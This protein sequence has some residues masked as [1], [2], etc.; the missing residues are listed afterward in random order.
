[1]EVSA[2][3][4]WKKLGELEDRAIDWKAHPAFEDVDPYVA[5]ADATHFAGTGVG[6]KPKRL[7]FLIRLAV[8]KCDPAMLA[9]ATLPFTMTGASRLYVGTGPVFVT[10]SIG[11]EHVLALRTGKCINIGTDEA[12]DWRQIEIAAVLAAPRVSNVD[13]TTAGIAAAKEISWASRPLIAFVDD[14]CPFANAAYLR[15]MGG[16]PSTRV[17]HLWDQ[18]SEIAPQGYWRPVPGFG[19]GRQISAVELDKVLKRN[20]LSATEVDEDACYRELGLD[21]LAGARFS[22]GA[23]MM[24]LAAGAPDPS[25]SRDC[26]ALALDAA[27]QADII[28]VQLP[29]DVM[30]DTS[31]GGLPRHVLD[32]LRYIDLMAIEIANGKV[33]KRPVVV[34]LSVGAAAGPHDGT[35]LVEQAIDDFIGQ[36]P[37]CAVVAAAGNGRSRA[38]HAKTSLPQQGQSRFVWCVA[39]DDGTDSF[40]ELWVAR[41]SDSGRSGS[42]AVRLVPPGK[43]ADCCPWVEPGEGF[44]GL[45]EGSNASDSAIAGVINTRRAGNSLSG[46]LILCAVAPTAHVEG[47]KAEPLQPL[48]PPGT[49][50]V[51]VWNLGDETTVV[52]AWI[53]RDE[54]AFGGSGRQ[55]QFDEHLE[56]TPMDEQTLSSLAHGARTIVVGGYVQRPD[57]ELDPHSG[58]G[59][60]RLGLARMGPDLL[61]PSSEEDSIPGMLS[62][63]VHSA[64]FNRLLGTSCSAAIVSRRLFNDWSTHGTPK[65]D[66][67][68]IK[69]QLPRIVDDTRGPQEPEPRVGLGRVRIPGC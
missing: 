25:V 40:M 32:A 63:G 54:P 22:H 19:Y 33:V 58:E 15:V 46:N 16:E 17:A 52:S 18:D 12:P 2:A 61:A 60:G 48:A 24:G 13:S 28:F 6:A 45:S 30:R 37:A 29:H 49:W 36:R 14:G 67:E 41:N 44:F 5:W 59:P 62:Y 21:Q 56:P 23:H 10:G 55:S 64:E 42:V 43:S 20:V 26:A 35:S 8:A 3:W 51:H 1:V 27:S 69:R 4:A 39:P 50:E 9:A 31:G 38:L 57:Q 47:G 65:P 11:V 7:P 68:A 53:E 34:N 66:W